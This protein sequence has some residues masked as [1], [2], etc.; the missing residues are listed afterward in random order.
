MTKEEIHHTSPFHTWVEGCSFSPCWRWMS[1]I[2]LSTALVQASTP[3]WRGGNLGPKLCLWVPKSGWTSFPEK[4]TSMSIR[5]FSA[6]VNPLEAPL[7]IAGLCRE[8]APLESTRLKGDVGRLDWMPPPRTGFRIYTADGPR[9][10]TFVVKVTLYNSS[11]LLTSRSS[12][13]IK[14]VVTIGRSVNGGL[15]PVSPGT[16]SSRH[17]L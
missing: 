16:S 2:P 9:I 10:I 12:L 5:R 6:H 1:L 4:S 17:D 3:A 11:R 13:I 15:P 7:P 14:R 8:E